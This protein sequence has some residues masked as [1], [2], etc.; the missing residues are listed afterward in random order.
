MKENP[1]LYVLHCS[2]CNYKRFS[3]GSDISDL[4]QIKQSNIPRNT[5]KLDIVNKK[6][7]TAPDKKRAKMFKCPKCGFTIKSYKIETV[8]EEKET[9]TENE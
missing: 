7:V 8:E 9:E 1:S 5:P 6:I 4:L 3:N 2:K